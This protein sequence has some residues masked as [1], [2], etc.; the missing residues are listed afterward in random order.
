MKRCNGP[1]TPALRGLGRELPISPRELEIATLASRGRTNRDIA[2][3]LTL[4]VRTHHNHL[5]NVYQKLGIASRD[6]L[7]QIL[8]PFGAVAHE[9]PPDLD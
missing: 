4:S 2:G 6:E 3:H 9:W 8:E 7:V 5:H 1:T